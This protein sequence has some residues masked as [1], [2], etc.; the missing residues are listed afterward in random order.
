[1]P[2]AQFLKALTGPAQES[3]QCFILLFFPS[4]SFPLQFLLSPLALALD[5]IS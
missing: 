3:Q 5:L 2:L 1:M 4:F